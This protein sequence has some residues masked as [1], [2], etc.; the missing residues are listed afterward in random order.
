M[1]YQELVNKPLPPGL[2]AATVALE[3]GREYWAGSFRGDRDH[4]LSDS[5]RQVRV[6]T[7]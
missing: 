4:A 5:G 3:V 1:T 2:F 6:C 7:D